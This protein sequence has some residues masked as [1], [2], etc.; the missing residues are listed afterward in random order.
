MIKTISPQDL[1]E[2][3]SSPNSEYDYIDVRSPAEYEDFHLPGTINIPLDQLVENVGE[4]GQDKT[5]ITI[6]AK[7]IRSAKASEFLLAIGFDTLNLEGGLDNWLSAGMQ[8][9]K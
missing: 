9:P 1:H 7:G 8:I 2:L 3:L 5:L 6:C 4:L